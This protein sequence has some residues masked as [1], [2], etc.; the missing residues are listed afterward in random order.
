MFAISPPRE[1][2]ADVQAEEMFDEEINEPELMPQ[3]EFSGFIAHR[4]QKYTKKKATQ[5][6]LIRYDKCDEKMRTALRASRGAE[7]K[8]WTDF[9]A[10]ENIPNQRQRSSSK[11]DTKSLDVNGLRQ[12]R[13]NT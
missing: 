4:T 7:W 8:K 11:K 12:T 5:S 3:D 6:R 10:G 2:D 1:Q 9:D 13:T